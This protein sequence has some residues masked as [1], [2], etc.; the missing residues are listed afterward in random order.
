MQVTQQEGRVASISRSRDLATRS[1]ALPIH[2]RL[3][4]DDVERV[5]DGVCSWFES[6]A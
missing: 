3:T 4:D 6:R 1:F 2:A 5:I